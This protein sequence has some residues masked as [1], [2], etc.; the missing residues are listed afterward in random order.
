MAFRIGPGISPP[1][2]QL[3]RMPM[4]PKQML[5]AFNSHIVAMSEDPPIDESEDDQLKGWGLACSEM[6]RVLNTLRG[7]IDGE[8]PKRN[9]PADAAV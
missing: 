3:E 9:E 8:D 2:F 4:T 7:L 1:K 5:Y 6:H